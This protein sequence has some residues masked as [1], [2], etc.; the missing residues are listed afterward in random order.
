MQWDEF[1]SSLTLPDKSEVVPTWASELKHLIILP[2]LLSNTFTHLILYSL[3]LGDA[4][5][6]LCCE[7]Q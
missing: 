7:L 2:L 1:I 6:A 5:Q 3:W 4:D